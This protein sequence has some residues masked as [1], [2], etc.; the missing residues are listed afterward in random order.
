MKALFYSVVVLGILVAV[1]GYY[2][3]WFSTAASPSRQPDVIENTDQ[4][5]FKDD[6]AK[7]KVGE[8]SKKPLDPPKN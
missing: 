1:L 6:S 3:N 2:R 4:Q 7:T 5:K 8:D